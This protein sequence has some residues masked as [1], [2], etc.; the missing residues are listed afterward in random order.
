MVR[1]PPAL[2]DDVVHARAEHDVSALAR[3]VPGPLRC[4]RLALG[5]GG[6]FSGAPHRGRER[7]GCRV[8]R[9]SRRLRRDPLGRRRVSALARR[10]GVAPARGAAPHRAR[11]RDPAPVVRDGLRHQPAQS[12]GRAALPHD[13]LAV[14]P[15]GTRWRARAKPRARRR[16]DRHQ[17]RL[18]PDGHPRRRV[19]RPLRQRAPARRADPALGHG[20]RARRT[21]LAACRFRR[22]RKSAP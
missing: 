17:R 5:R 13:L 18:Q 22:A 9:H 6:G 11:P 10:Q 2:R 14:H 1:L 4:A 12:A 7:A 3:A 20:H 19:A 21:G 16:A 15:P 8:A